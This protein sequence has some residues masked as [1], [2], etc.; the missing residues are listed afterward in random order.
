M[1][2]DIKINGE[3]APRGRTTVFRVPVLTDLDGNEIAL[4]IHAVV[5]AKPGPTLAIH[6]VTHGSEWQS[7]D[8]TRCVVEGLDPAEMS[9]TLLALPIA[10]PIALSSRTRN[11]RDESDSPDL[12][13]SFGGVQ[14]WIADQLGR[15]IVATLYRNADAV[16]DFHSGIWGSTMG[17]VTCGRD[18]SD[19]AVSE[20]AFRMARAFGLSHI[21]RSDFVTRFPG[22]KSGVGYAGET[23][24]IPGIISEIGGGGFEPAL[25]KRWLD[26][27]VQGVMGVLR[28][29]G[30]LPGQPKIADRILIYDTVQRV[31]P[32]NGG[33]LE[34]VFDPED[35]MRREVAKGELLG[36]VWSP[37]TFEVIEELRSPMRALVDMAARPY[38]VR[39][40]DWAYL[41]VD[42]D[43]PG[44]RWLERDELP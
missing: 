1:G 32:S 26:E 4:T 40:G 37:Y 19:P 20:R 5:G 33:I 30:I 18:F 21:R 13:R 24:R 35:L 7:A 15:A 44:S 27:N 3:L 9:G 28:E 43:S 8:I 10:N 29:M 34:P 41:L 38:P 2:T 23:M 6:T 22:P 16:I 11:L 12:N 31:N 42:L 14:T 39:P 25:E 17:S 36:R